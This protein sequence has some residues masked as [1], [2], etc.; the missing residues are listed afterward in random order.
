MNIDLVSGFR[1][2]VQSTVVRTTRVLSTLLSVVAKSESHDKFK[3]TRTSVPYLAALVSVVEEVRT[4]CPVKHR[5]VPVSATSNTNPANV[6]T[7]VHSVSQL[8]QSHSNTSIVDF[9]GAGPFNALS[10]NPTPNC[11]LLTIQQGSMVP[12]R[13]KSWDSSHPDKTRKGGGL[14]ALSS[15]R[16][17][18]VPC[19]AR[20][21]HSFDIEHAVPRILT[22]PESTLIQLP[23]AKPVTPAIAITPQTV[24]EI[25]T[26]SQVLLL[27]SDCIACNVTLL[28]HRRMPKPISCSIPMFSLTHRLKRFC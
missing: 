16:L 25:Q 5:P 14:H 17:L 23:K 13:Q 11:G 18:P 22:K 20:H 4:R 10:V 6:A 21:W 24:P 2:P 15:T 28:S 19:H 3:V 26:A 8:P 27:R 9:A 12:R 1:H 7:N